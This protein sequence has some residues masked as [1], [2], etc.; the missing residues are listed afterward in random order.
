DDVKDVIPSWVQK[1]CEQRS[2]Q[3][4]DRQRSEH[5]AGPDEHSAADR[6]VDKLQGDETHPLRKGLRAIDLGHQ[7]ADTQAD[8]RDANEDE[9]EPPLDVHSGIQELEI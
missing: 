1:R 7:V 2:V 3:L 6:A 8:Q 9:D 4:E 5:Y